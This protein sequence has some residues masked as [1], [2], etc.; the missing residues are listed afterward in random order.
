MIATHSDISDEDQSVDYPLI[1]TFAT[2]DDGESKTA[3]VSNNTVVVDNVSF[4]N[5]VT[6]GHEYT[7]RGILMDKSTGESLKDVNGADYTRNVIDYYFLY[8]SD[9]YKIQEMRYI[10]TKNL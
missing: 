10:N 4:E 2:F 5:V 1:S 3:R 6:G 9:D 7:I 8:I